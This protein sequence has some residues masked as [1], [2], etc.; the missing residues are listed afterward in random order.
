MSSRG[1]K[2]TGPNEQQIAAMRQ[3]LRVRKLEPFLTVQARHQLAAHVGLPLRLV[4]RWLAQERLRP[5]L[6]FVLRIAPKP[7]SSSSSS[8][9]PR[10]QASPSSAECVPVAPALPLSL[11]L[12]NLGPGPM[13]AHLGDPDVDS[14]SCLSEDKRGVC[15]DVVRQD[16]VFSPCESTDTDAKVT[17]PQTHAPSLPFADPLTW[18]A[19]LLEP[20]LYEPLVPQTLSCDVACDL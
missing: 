1:S 10:R 15:D 3:W 18:P 11:S 4:Q 6:R 20:P 9:L 7:A 5:R 14:G 12:P 17:S 8:S 2:P 19:F 13:P 16:L